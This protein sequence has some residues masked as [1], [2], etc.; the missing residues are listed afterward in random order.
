MNFKPPLTFRFKL[1]A[2]ASQVFVEDGRGGLLLYVRQKL[3]KIRED[4]MIYHDSQQVSPA[5]RIRADRW[6]DFNAEY[7]ITDAAG[8]HL[9]SVRRRGARSI[10]RATYEVVDLFGR[11]TYFIE[12][13]S[14]ILGLLNG[15]FEMIPFL[16]HL[17]GYFLNPTYLISDASR[18]TVMKLVK[19]PAF[20]E[21]RYAL[22][23]QSAVT[24]ADRELIALALVMMTLLERSRG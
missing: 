15:L 20:W 8:R 2:L 12:Q 16:G 9:G 4:V 17:S 10:F 13:E 19:Q 3:M 1:I 5:Y 24:E 22:T 23:E 21:G 14:V 18:R 11:P 7:F 6:L